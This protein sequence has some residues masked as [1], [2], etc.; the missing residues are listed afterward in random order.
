MENNIQT[1]INIIAILYGKYVGNKSNI[2]E[3][4]RFR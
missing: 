1:K 4:S 2:E 3:P